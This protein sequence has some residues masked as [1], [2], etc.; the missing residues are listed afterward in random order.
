[1]LGIPPLALPQH[2]RSAYAL[3]EFAES[4]EEDPPCVAAAFQ[5]RHTPRHAALYKFG[6]TVGF[7]STY[8]RMVPQLN[9]VLTPEL[10]LYGSA[11]GIPAELYAPLLGPSTAGPNAISGLVVQS[12]KRIDVY[13]RSTY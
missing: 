3:R 11:A 9:D 1:M 13:I 4:L 5:F 12:V 8:R 7:V 10:R 2:R 6:A